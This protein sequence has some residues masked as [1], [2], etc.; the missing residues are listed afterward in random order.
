MTARAV[1]VQVRRQCAD[2]LQAVRGSDWE[3]G[4]KQRRKD[5]RPTTPPSTIFT[6]TRGCWD[7]T[8]G[9]EAAGLAGPV[10]W[11]V[12]VRLAR[13]A[14]G[15]RGQVGGAS[16]LP[17]QGTRGWLRAPTARG[18]L[19]REDGLCLAWELPSDPQERVCAG[20]TSPSD[21]QVPGRPASTDLLSCKYTFGAR[22]TLSP[23]KM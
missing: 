9:Y 10:V 3:G 19:L 14:A 12:S 20:M 23:E 11:F 5:T 17:W 18:D 4:W 2:S 21:S 22:L 8:A 1:T 7:V 16:S 13:W 15:A 6:Q